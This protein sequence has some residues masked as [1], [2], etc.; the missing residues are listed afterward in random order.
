MRQ[1]R[2]PI[3]SYPG[4]GQAQTNARALPPK[5]DPGPVPQTGAGHLTVVRPEATRQASDP[6]PV[7]QA[8][9]GYG[10]DGVAADGG[11]SPPPQEMPTA[12]WA[13][14]R[15][16]TLVPARPNWPFSGRPFQP[17]CERMFAT[18]NG[19]AYRRSKKALA[20]RKSVIVL[21]SAARPLPPGR[22]RHEVCAADS[23]LLLA[24]LADSPA[25]APPP[26]LPREGPA[27][28]AGRART[29]QPA[30]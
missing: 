6:R 14:G 23:A 28:S 22:A 17:T 19:S 21:A 7:P 15:Q 11:T 26:P 29:R 9:R 1:E 2:S 30:A 25:R 3:A 27:R 8:G 12:C 24:A 4:Q 18:S 10:G 20:R 13:F 5:S 16:P